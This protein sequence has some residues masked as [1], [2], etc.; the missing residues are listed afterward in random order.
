[1][2][3]WTFARSRAVATRRITVRSLT[4]RLLPMVVAA[5]ALLALPA[6]ASGATNVF[7]TTNTFEGVNSPPVSFER[8]G[9]G[10]GAMVL[11][12]PAN[13]ETFGG[14]A[15]ISTTPGNW[16]SVRTD[17]LLLPGA[18]C[19]LS[20]YINP[21]GAPVTL[22][23]EVIDPDTWTYTALKTVTLSGTT[24]QQV[25]MS[26]RPAAA[27]REDQVFRVSV[28]DPIRPAPQHTPAI[29]LAH[30]DSLHSQCVG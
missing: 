21:F 6:S 7:T 13:A 23:V 18:P 28:T 24:Y 4:L 14:Y 11:N 10:S 20:I 16:S 9:S 26:F 22:N 2:A 3:S 1:M 17:I 29:A 25:S 30:V 19:S 15:V 27:V 12:D 8:A 5:T